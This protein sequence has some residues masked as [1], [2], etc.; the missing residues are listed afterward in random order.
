MR[1]W[2]G[3]LILISALIMM[4]ACSGGSTTAEILPLPT[5]SP[6]SIP[7]ELPTEAP[8][9]IPEPVLTTLIDGLGRELS[10]ETPFQRIV[11]IAPSNTE[12]LFAVGA[13]EQVV[14]REDFADY[15]PE[16]LDVPSIGSTYG[17]LNLEAILGLEPDLI[18]AADITPSEQIQAM[19][20]VGLTVF[21]IGNP[22]E[23]EDLFSNIET[24][25]LLTGHD[26]EAQVL[27]G[28]LRARYEA[29]LTA[30][31][32]AQQVKLFY[33]ID[34]TDPTAPWTT[35]S[36]T[37][38]QLMFTLAGGDNVASDIEM[39]G[40]INLEALVVRDPDV[41]L[42]ATGPFIPT[43]VDSLLAR[44][45]WGEISAVANGQVF[46]IDTDFVDVPGPRLMDGF[47]QIARYLH[48]DLF[49]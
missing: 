21:V 25:G 17:E 46:A 11:S 1:R 20:D 32:G 16:A 47:E 5:E 36:G 31:E 49:E 43:T 41:I 7:T 35:G 22:A 26:G 4:A 28:E 2:T 34:G 27:A 15:P 12:I 38:Q 40:Q 13:G 29:V 24:A 14:G 39:W 18:L 33:E 6:T 45:G 9:Q 3:S 42:F 23:F 48:P 44:S 37:F 19:E 8:T 30:V 10:F